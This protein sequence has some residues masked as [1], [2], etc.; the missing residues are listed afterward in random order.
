MYSHVYG[1]SGNLPDELIYRQLEEALSTLMGIGDELT[2]QSQEIAMASIAAA[3]RK[4]Q[5]SSD[6]PRLSYMQFL[7]TWRSI[8]KSARESVLTLTVP[9]LDSSEPDPAFLWFIDEAIEL[10]L[11][12]LLHITFVESALKSDDDY[13]RSM[14]AYS[15]I[16]L[17]VSYWEDA[18]QIERRTKLFEQVRKDPSPSVRAELEI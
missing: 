11:H 8:P 17:P 13:V 15:L 12:A 2:A 7:E 9:H 10:G 6:W 16:Q 14:A 1:E 3:I 5:A 18:G 4:Y